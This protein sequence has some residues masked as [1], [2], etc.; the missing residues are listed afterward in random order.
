M[1]ARRLPI[2]DARTTGGRLLGLLRAHAAPIGLVLALQLGAAASSV[3]LPWIVGDIVDGIGIGRGRDWVA[4]RLAIAVGLVVINFALSWAAVARSRVLGETIF[5]ALRD[6]LVD[7]VVHLPLST[8]ETAGSGDLIGRTTNDIERV[9]VMIRQGLSSIL[10]LTTTVVVTLIASF[11]AA[12]SL[13]W[14]L[15]V[16]IGLVVLVARW[17]LPRTIPAYRAS[18]AVVARFSG[19]LS[20]T[21]GHAPSVDALRLGPAR[22]RAFDS[23]LAQ[24]WR[25]E[26]YGAWMRVFL[27]IGMVLATLGPVTALIVLGAAGVGAG[28]L[29]A[30]TVTTAVMYCYQIRIPLW[31]A[32]FWIDE[33]QFAWTS[34]QRIFGVDLVDPDRRPLPGACA[35]GPIRVEG[36]SY[37]YRDGRPVLHGVD[38]DLRDGETLAVVGPSGAGKSTLGRMIAGIHPPVSGRV[39][40]GGVDL[41]DLPEDDLRR[42]VVLVTQEHHVFVG[43]LADNVRMVRS[44]ATD[45]EVWE[46]L[47]AV[48]ADSWAREAGGLGMRVGA[49]G[50][51]LTPAR[52]QQVALARIALMNPGTLVLDEATSLLDPASARTVEASMAR[53]LSGRTVVAI[54]HRLDTARAADRIAVMVDGRI[55]ELGAHDEL[56]AADGEYARLWEAWNRGA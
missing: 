27:F 48:G 18:S 21:I 30:G 49:G 43:T 56:V 15:L 17:Y 22:H 47:A 16:E 40:S 11:A 33:L 53:V 23:M 54:A 2:A 35:D 14:V 44:D 55:V 8:V 41:V 24:M 4:T 7:A 37:A 38:L 29:T 45:D 39:T 5:A 20:E 28:A 19:H 50:E 51:Q 13:A 10:V 25:V 46:A 9:Q 52:A 34:L 12:P 6:G 32:T 42:R 3:A 1:S 31:E 26:R 36:V